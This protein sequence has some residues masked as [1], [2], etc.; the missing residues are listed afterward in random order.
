M[1]IFGGIP[2][3]GLALFAFALIVIL[4]VIIRRRTTP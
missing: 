4:L 2:L 3:P 1:T